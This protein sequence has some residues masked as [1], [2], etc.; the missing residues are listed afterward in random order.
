MS[1]HLKNKSPVA[2]NGMYIHLIYLVAIL[3]TLLSTPQT[4]RMLSLLL[5]FS[6]KFI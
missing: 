3:S 2:T 1:H 5:L 4:T 6:K